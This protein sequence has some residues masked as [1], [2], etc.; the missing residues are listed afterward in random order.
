MD[1]PQLVSP[2]NHRNP[3]TSLLPL[4]MKIVQFVLSVILFITLVSAVPIPTPD[5]SFRGKLK[6]KAGKAIVNTKAKIWA[7]IKA[8][9]TVSHMMTFRQPHHELLI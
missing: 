5:P 9:I 2:Y 1:E 6:E 3:K 8:K 7:P 4:T